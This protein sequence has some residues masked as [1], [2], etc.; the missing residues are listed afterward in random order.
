MEIT[1]SPAS[2]ILSPHLWFDFTVRRKLVT[3]PTITCVNLRQQQKK[4]I[5]AITIK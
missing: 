3:I 1:N 2:P 5:L 4:S